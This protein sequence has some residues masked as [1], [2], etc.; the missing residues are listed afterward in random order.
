MADIISN[1]KIF[2]DFG[3]TPGGSGGGAILLD[4]VTQMKV[5]DERKVEVTKAI[6]KKRGAGFRRKAGGG[7][8]TLTEDRHRPR[9]VNWRKLQNEGKIFTIIAAD[10]DGGEREKFLSC[11]VS[12]VGR[13]ASAEGEHQDEIEI[14]FLD[15]V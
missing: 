12:N 10:E 9:Q 2:A 6:G 5:T 1:G 4:Y 8:L 13:S 14:A 7:M 3:A 11:T 15:S